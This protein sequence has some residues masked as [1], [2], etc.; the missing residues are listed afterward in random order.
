MQARRLRRRPSIHSALGQCIVF[1][2]KRALSQVV[3]ACYRYYPVKRNG[4]TQ[5]LKPKGMLEIRV[6]TFYAKAAVVTMP[7]D[8]L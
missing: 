8:I 2:G 5:L 6:Y 1:A 4:A 3:C 7:P